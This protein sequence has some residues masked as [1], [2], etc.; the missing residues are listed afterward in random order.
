M[1]STL[2][3]LIAIYPKAQYWLQLSAVYSE[4]GKAEKELSVLETA[5][6]QSLL[7]NESQIISLAQAMLALDVPYKSAQ[8]IIDGMKSK[9]VKENGKNLS[10]LGDAFMIAKEYDQAIEIMGQA[11]N[12]TQQGKDFYKLAQIY[13]ERQEWLPAL[14]SVNS[15]LVDEQL[16]NVEDALVLKGLIL[17]NLNDLDEAKKIFIQAKEFENSKESANQWLAYINGESKR[18]QYMAQQTSL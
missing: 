18:Q 12:L 3:E 14:K 8:I 13:T 1:E 11:A 16:N 5:Y 15:A 7:K 17:F 10:L 2:K 9:T 6:D 4:L